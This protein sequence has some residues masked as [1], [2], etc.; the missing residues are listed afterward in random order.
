MK[1]LALSLL[2]LGSEAFVPKFGA[3]R[4]EPGPDCW[5][6]YICTTPGNGLNTIMD[7]VKDAVECYE[8]CQ[9]TQDCAFFTFRLLWGGKTACTVL[10]NCDTQSTC[11]EPS[12]CASG[13]VD[14]SA[15][16]PC[17]KLTYET[18]A[19]TWSCDEFLDPYSVDIPSGYS[20]HTSC[21]GWESEDGSD[22]IQAS[23]KCVNGVWEAVIT[24]LPTAVTINTPDTTTLCSCKDFSL[25]Y[26]PNDEPGAHFYCENTDVSQASPENPLTLDPAEECIL[27]CDNFLVA[28]IFC[29]N[30]G[31]VDADPDMGIACYKAPPTLPG[32]DPTTTTT[33]ST[34]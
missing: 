30:G 18:G 15:V 19:A 26:N 14:C 2:V 20:C 23:S 8:L 3:P 27:M 6:D 16:T 10:D 34:L 33:E 28:N 32:P 4:A 5:F 12:N 31:W 9:N 13:P 7:D 21:E 24:S 11:S 22:S 25:W 17:P 29:Q 1:F